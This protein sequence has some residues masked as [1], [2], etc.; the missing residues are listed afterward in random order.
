MYK[1]YSNYQT[2]NDSEARTKWSGLLL[3]PCRYTLDKL[4][5]GCSFFDYS[6][7]QSSIACQYYSSISSLTC[8]NAHHHTHMEKHVWSFRLTYTF[9][10][11]GGKLIHWIY[12]D[13]DAWVCT[14]YFVCLLIYMFIYLLLIA[15]ISLEHWS[16]FQVNW[17][18]SKVFTF[19]VNIYYIFELFQKQKCVPLEDLAAEFK[20]RTQVRP[21]TTWSWNFLC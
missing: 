17:Y 9:G 3:T 21:K 14:S 13:L 4:N 18:N 15:W 12:V 7:C 2:S 11:D 10:K 6:L 8:D 16:M 5:S 19:L 1:L 20:L